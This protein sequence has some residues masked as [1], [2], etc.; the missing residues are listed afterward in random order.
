MEVYDDNFHGV[1]FFTDPNLPPSYAPFNIA[2]IGSELFVTFA[3]QDAAM[4]DDV[5]GQGHGIVDRFDLGGQFLRRFA[6][7]GQLNSPWGMAVAP[8]NFGDLAGSLWI[9]N[10]GDGNINAFDLGSGK[11]LGQ[12]R[13]TN[14]KPIVI[15]GLWSLEVGNGGN[16]GRT[17]T[18]Y[19]TAGP[20]GEK[21]GLFGG[22]FPSP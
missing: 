12:V 22:L 18:I 14:A 4:H 19:F 15:D 10:F 6:N 3:V 8:A 17:D 9:G 21:D 5:T 1:T 7:H 20:N 16:G 13:D 2:L 11:S